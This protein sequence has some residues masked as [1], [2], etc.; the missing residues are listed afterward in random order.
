MQST[1]ELRA[2]LGEIL[3]ALRDTTRAARVTFRVDLPERG[4]HCND[5]AAEAL[6]PGVK[7]L[8]GQ[9]AIDQRA[10]GSIR[11]LDD[12]K[13]PLVQNDLRGHV[14]P[15]PPP[16]LMSI[17]GVTAQ[18]LGPVVRGGALTGW[19]SVHVE[20]GPRQWAEA[21]VRALESAIDRVQHE[22]DGGDGPQ[23]RRLAGKIALI[24]GG[25]TGIG[26]GVAL[27][28][29]DEGADVAIAWIAREPDARSLVTE[30]ERRGRRG[31]AVR[32]DVTSEADVRA[33]V[34]SVVK[35]F[36]RLDVLVN[37]AGIQ[38][39]QPITEMSLDDW[40]RMMAVHLRG[41]FLCSREAARVMIP[42]GSGRIILLSSQLAYIGRA[43]YTAYSAAKGGLLTF[44]RALAQELAPHRILV[45]A[46]AP[47]LIDT[48]FDP[49]P[50]ATKRAHAAS[51]PLRRLGMPE[52]LVGAFVFLAADDSR[53]FC[54]QT[55]HPNGG[56]I[57]P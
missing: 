3:A 9:T 17:F 46:I 57:M 13:R 34:R 22:L 44:T 48:G 16:E 49:L 15:A 54:G 52:D 56:E 4:L 10:A 23:P 19:I 27:A 11:W 2:R 37:N 25:N 18:M 51:L 38:K 20:G 50:D 40:E 45:N 29:A 8:R 43:N 30:I 36:G 14:E 5:V 39:A 42:Q 55:L 26:R 31:L 1:V 7:S 28:Y 35:R 32:C 47:G 41:A 21:D 33:L 24:T 12:S 6:A 53:Y